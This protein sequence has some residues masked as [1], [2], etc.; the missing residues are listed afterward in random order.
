VLRGDEWRWWPLAPWLLWQG[1]AAR[2]R[3]P[4]LP[5]VVDRVGE[6]EGSAPALDLI[7]LGDSTIAGVGC[8]TQ[9]E[10][11]TGSTARY[12]ASRSG[13]AVRWRAHGV[14]GLTAAGIRRTLLPGALQYAPDVVVLSVGVNDAVRGRAPADFAADLAAIV[15]ALLAAANERG[16]TVRVIYAGMPPMGCFP[17]LQW[18]LAGLLAARAVALA[19]AAAD[20]LEGRAAV[21]RFPAALDRDTFASDGFHPG[22]VGC[23]RWSEWVGALALR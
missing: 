13:R 19:A 23:A 18:P 11:L 17:A 10:A 5:P 22:P 1:L 15:D 6:C 8:V 3:V 2:T 4:R 7:A 16:R 9:S 14:S 20:A 12:L 21:V